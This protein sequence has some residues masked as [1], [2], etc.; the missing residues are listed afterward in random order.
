MGLAHHEMWR[1]EYQAWL[2]A[3]DAESIAELF[4]NLTYEGNPALWHLLLYALSRVWTSPFVM[5]VLSGAIGVATVAVVFRS[6]PFPTLWKVLLSFGYY[7]VFEFTIISRVYGLGLLLALL[8]CAWSPTWRERPVRLAIVL[9]LL[10]NTTV[11]G[12][13]IAA[14]FLGLAIWDAWRERA[15]VIARERVRLSVCAVVVLIMCGASAA[16]IYPEPDNTFPVS[17]PA[18][19]DADRLAQSFGRVAAAYVPIPRLG[20]RH[21]WNTNVLDSRTPTGATSVPAWVAPL[22]SAALVLIFIAY[23]RHVPSVALFYTAGT[24]AFVGLTYLTGF[25][26][27]RYTGHLFVLL[28]VSMWLA[29]A[30]ARRHA[31][32]VSAP[33]GQFAHSAFTV[34]LVLGVIG[35]VGTWHRDYRE[36]FSSSGQAARYLSQ[37]GLDRDE[38][39]AMTDFTTAPLAAIL[40]RQLFYPQQHGPGSFTRWNTRR[41]DKMSHADMIPDVEAAVRRSASG[42]VVVVLD[43]P[44]VNVDAATGRSR[45]FNEGLLTRDL[46]I[47]LVH[48]SPPGIVLDEEYFVYLV[49]PAAR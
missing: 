10:A 23:L 33:F 6:A 48:H 38:M 31:Q 26:A 24:A 21:F 27:T 8:A 36:P 20:D 7:L 19:L 46:M 41:I 9:A 37:S 4:G 14:G 12:L 49:S 2:V 34:L 5:Q 45:M 47:R 40:N 25:T 32:P 35:G 17:R 15:T 1:D 44:L 39:V 22:A 43:L 13:I 3:R 11:F 29:L 42:R 16:Q 18:G 28:V 30:R